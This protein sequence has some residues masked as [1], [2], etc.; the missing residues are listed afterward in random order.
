MRLEGEA[1]IDFPFGRTLPILTTGSDYLVGFNPI[2][3]IHG[4]AEVA[5]LDGDELGYL[6]DEVP[7]ARRVE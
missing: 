5:G 2:R 6:V 1:R 3:N 4:T 7:E